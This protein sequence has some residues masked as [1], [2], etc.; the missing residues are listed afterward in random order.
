MGK[1]TLALQIE[2]ALQCLTGLKQRCGYPHDAGDSQAS[3]TLQQTRLVEDLEELTNVMEELKVAA[4]AL[5][6]RNKILEAES[7]HYQDL[8]VCAPVDKLVTDTE[9]LIEQDITE[10]LRV[11]KILRERTYELGERVKELNCLFSISELIEKPEVSLEEV[12]KGTTELIP[13]AWQY[14]EITCA[15][16]IL[17]DRVY[18]TDNFKDT[19]WKQ[20]SDILVNGERVGIVDVCYLEIRPENDDGPFLKEERSLIQAIADSLGRIVEQ[21]WTHE[22]LRKSEALNRAILEAIPDMLFQ[23]RQDGTVQRFE[24]AKDIGLPMPPGEFL[25]KKISEVMP[26]DNARQ[27]MRCVELTLETEKMQVFEYQLEINKEMHDYEARYV[28]CGQDEVLSVVRDITERK[29]SEA[30]KARLFESINE[31]R[32][33]LRA[34]TGRL[35]DTREGERKALARELHDQVGQNLTALNLNLNIIRAQLPDVTSTT[36]DPIQTL[37]DDS[38]VL[39]EQ[40]TERVQNVMA[41]L[42]PPVLDDYGLVE[43]LRWYGAQL[44]ARVRFTITVVG[45]EP[46]PRLTSSVENALFR[47][48]QEA[49]TN[50]TKHAQARQVTVMVETDNGTVRLIVTDDGL[51]FDSA[52]RAN[53][54]RRRSWGLITMAERTE[55]I[56]GRFRIESGSGQGTKVIVEV[57]Q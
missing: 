29:Q 49:L 7:R 45:K 18:K 52:S 43:A 44:A 26:S 34:L 53:S 50:V 42:R 21:I 4:T 56:G 3:S 47:I 57:P 32:D 28:P 54:T 14:P 9:N 15:Q 27:S 40:T 22:A 17:E 8:V 12:L 20:S 36:T 1:G 33:Q 41:N 39:L 23:I 35:A 30:E 46:V 2:A 19:I 6:A 25:G 24:P 10:R 37:L 31:Q 11:K 16:I 51:G 48:T 13:P 38:L 55:A 5:Q